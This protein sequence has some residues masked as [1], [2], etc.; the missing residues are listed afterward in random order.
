MPQGERICGGEH[1]LRDNERLAYNYTFIL[2][3]IYTKYHILLQVG[4]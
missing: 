1:P 2:L 3:Y 4:F